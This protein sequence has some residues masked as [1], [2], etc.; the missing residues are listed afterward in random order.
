MNDQA[1]L[2][3]E[4][5]DATREGTVWW[6]GSWQCRNWHGYFS[7]ARAGAGIGVSSFSLSAEIRLATAEQNCTGS[8][9]RRLC[10]SMRKTVFS[11]VGDA[12]AAI[13]GIIEHRPLQ[14]AGPTFFAAVSR[15]AV[16]YAHVSLSAARS[17]IRQPP[18]RSD[19]AARR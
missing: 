11:F 16:C 6:A 5:I 9:V 19:T 18:T 15:L 7:T 12:M 1:D 8:L 4:L 2:F 14:S 10:R 3:P 13:V 17:L